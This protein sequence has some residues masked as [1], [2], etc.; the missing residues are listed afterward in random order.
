MAAKNGPQ[1]FKDFCRDVL[2]IY[3][4]KYMRRWKTEIKMQGM[5]EDYERKLFSGCVRAIEA[6]LEELHCA[7][8][9]AVCYQQERTFGIGPMKIMV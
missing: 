9:R 8:Q 5:E 7:G 4:T 2:E 6:V 1:Y 3:G